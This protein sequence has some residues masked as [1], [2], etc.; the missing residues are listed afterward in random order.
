MGEAQ[1]I[2]FKIVDHK[3]RPGMKAI[4]VW[5]GEVFVAAVYPH[6]DGLRIVSK[7]MTD[8]AKETKPAFYDLDWLPSAVVKLGEKEVTFGS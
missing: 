1:N 3:V 2:K 7:Y 6:Q 5:R 8:V 4:E